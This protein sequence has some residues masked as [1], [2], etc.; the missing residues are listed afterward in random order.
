MLSNEELTAIKALGLVP[1][2][3]QAIISLEAKHRELLFTRG[4]RTVEHQAQVS[5]A[6]VIASGDQ[7]DEDISTVRGSQQL[8]TNKGELIPWHVQF[9]E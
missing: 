4:A 2:V 8:L 6:N 7:I 1:E 9:S 3:E 5:A